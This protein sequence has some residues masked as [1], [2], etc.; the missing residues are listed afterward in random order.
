MFCVQ[1]YLD[2]PPPPPNFFRG[3]S[4]SWKMV[5][6][7]P[8]AVQRSFGGMHAGSV[9][10]KDPTVMR[11]SVWYAG[12]KPVNFLGGITVGEGRVQGTNSACDGL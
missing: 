10:C 9:A 8:P 5:E 1:K 6:F 2:P 4:A 3:Y 7:D 11:S 12:G